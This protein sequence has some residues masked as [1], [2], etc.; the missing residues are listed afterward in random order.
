[1]N[2]LDEKI[3]ACPDIPRYFL[4]GAADEVVRLLE[5]L[6]QEQAGLARGVP[7]AVERLVGLMGQVNELNPFYRITMTSDGEQVTVSAAPRYEGA[8]LDGPVRIGGTFAFPDSEEGRRA[9]DELRRSVEFGTPVTVPAEYIQ[10]L[11]VDAPAGMGGVFVGGDLSIAA[12]QNAGEQLWLSVRVLDA[13]GHVVSA[14]VFRELNRTAGTKGVVVDFIDCGGALGLTLEVDIAGGQLMMNYRYTVPDGAL[15]ASLLPGLA[16]FNQWRPG[17]RIHLFVQG[18]EIA[19]PI[20]FPV[21]SEDR[22][23]VT[24]QLT[25]TLAELQ[26]RSNCFFPMPASFDLETR[27]EIEAARRLVAGETLRGEWHGIK[28]TMP[29]ATLEAR[30]EEI[31]AEAALGL[32]ADEA[33]YLV[34]DGHPMRIGTVR[35]RSSP[36]QLVSGPTTSDGEAGAGF[37]DLF[38]SPIG[39]PWST[40]V[41]LP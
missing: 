41:L 34:L 25:R 8:E 12:L 19:P 3:A 11:D 32:S 33:L 4:G 22:L 40:T 6:G 39:D 9:A 18:S 35:K 13:Q 17:R 15:P 20:D 27:R 23:D 7:D 36:A 28:M 30:R 5:Q 10:H 29:P 2:W 1:M 14:N 16:F 24:Y 38:F 31:L 26:I 37:V 21:T